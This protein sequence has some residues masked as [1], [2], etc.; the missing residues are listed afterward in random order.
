MP[1]AL[2][3]KN[4]QEVSRSGCSLR[5]VGGEGEYPSHQKV[6]CSTCFSL[7][8]LSEILSFFSRLDPG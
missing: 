2:Q 8:P 6:P 7:P 4:L 1:L 3:V 5:E